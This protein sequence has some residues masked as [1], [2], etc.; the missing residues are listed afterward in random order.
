MSA[1]NN[2]FFII[3][4]SLVISSHFVTICALPLY[5]LRQQQAVALHIPAANDAVIYEDQ[6]IPE[7]HE[8]QALVA[9]AR[10]RTSSDL[11]T[12]DDAQFSRSLYDHLE[13][14]YSL[15]ARERRGDS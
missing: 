13:L 14:E 11:Q 2:T 3:L 12:C 5:I 8:A 7:D 15:L 9:T 6:S 1:S 4:Y 10:I